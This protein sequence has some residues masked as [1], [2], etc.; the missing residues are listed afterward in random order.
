MFLSTHLF[1]IICLPFLRDLIFHL[2]S[3]TTAWRTSIT[4]FCSTGLWAKIYLSFSNFL[5]W[6]NLCFSFILHSFIYIQLFLAG[7]KIMLWQH[8]YFFWQKMLTLFYYLLA[9][10]ISNEMLVV[11]GISVLLYMLRCFSLAAFQVCL[12]FCYSAIWQ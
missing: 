8:F 3:L 12:S 5:I 2:L 6:N 10:I 1:T 11:I 4:H 9:S 7:C